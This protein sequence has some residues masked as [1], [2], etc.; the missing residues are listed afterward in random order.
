[1]DI[2][3]DLYLNKIISSAN[4]G[5]VKVI[6][7]IRRCGKSYLLFHLYKN[8]LLKKGVKKS[9]IITFELDQMKDA[10]YRNPLLLA[11]Y[12]HSLVDNKKGEY[13]LFIDEIQMAREVENPYDLDGDKLSI[14]D[15]LN[16]MK[17][18]PNLDVYVTGSNS[19]MLSSDIRT[20]FRGR[21]DEIRVMPLSFREYYE[22]VKGDKQEAFNNYAYYGGMPE[23]L[24]KKDAT[25]KMDYLAN[26]FDEVYLKDIVE[27]KGIKRIEVLEGII[28]LLSS[29]IGSL[30][31]PLNITNTIN[32]KM[33]LSKGDIVSNTTVIN[34][35][36]YLEDA[37]MFNKAE[38]FDVKGKEY[39]D[40]PLKYY[41]VDIGLRNA[42]T[43]FRQIEMTHI[44]ENII[45]NELL[46]RGYKVDVGVVYTNEKNK[47]GNYIKKA[48]E[49]DFVCKKG[50]MQ[51]Y[52][53]SAYAMIDEDKKEAELLPLKKVQDS[54]KKIIIRNDI[55]KH[56]YDDNGFLNI[57]IIDFLLNDEMNW[58][59]KI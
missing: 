38:R 14:Y 29:A 57:N 13:Y 17:N 26:L 34:Y 47:N 55:P 36:S 24:S 20:E 39:L 18:I 35:I 45:Y 4:D 59:Q 10:K 27:H 37:F 48:K 25:S 30:T 23:S 1:M 21:S 32:S 28:N 15:L 58:K 16:D 22:Y 44:N 43:G 5:R 33:K 6:T 2:K 42:R 11:E 31:N 9:H 53:Q 19:K 54:F 3:R 41:C 56:F 8:F 52:I 51:C 40:S 7:G 46:T 12:V 49:I 50:N